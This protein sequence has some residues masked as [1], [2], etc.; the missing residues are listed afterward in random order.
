VLTRFRQRLQAAG[1][2]RTIFET[3]L[4]RIEALGLLANRRRLR[5]DA[6]HLVAEVA[7]LNQAEA[8]QEAIR[9]V[10]EVYEQYPELRESF[11]FLWLYEAYGEE[12]WIGGS[13]WDEERLL[14]S[15]R[16]GYQLLELLGER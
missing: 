6:T 8:V 16:A 4:A 7:R 13:R 1:W 5:V 2:E 10:V 15:G 11:A 12:R 14:R 9:L 3:V